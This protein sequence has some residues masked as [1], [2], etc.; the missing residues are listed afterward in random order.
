MARYMRNDGMVAVLYSPGFG[1]G[2]ST[3]AEDEH[4]EYLAFDPALVAAVLAGDRNK[5]AQI[6]EAHDPNIYTG[7]ARDLT[8]HWLPAG[9][10]FEIE[11]YDGSETIHVI[12]G[13]SYLIA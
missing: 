11:E 3:W 8:V 10:V 1:A 5:A 4:K 6:A 7:G 13:R 9:T 2:W 12:G